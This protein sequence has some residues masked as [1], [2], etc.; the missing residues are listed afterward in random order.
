MSIA[1]YLVGYIMMI[2][3][4]AM[5]ADQLD[6]PMRWIGIG[7]L[8]WLGVALVNDVMASRQKRPQSQG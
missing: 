2:A 3:G 5:G 1:L 7:I 8:C 6:M 4:L